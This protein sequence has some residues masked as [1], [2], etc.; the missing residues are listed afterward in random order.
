MQKRRRKRRSRWLFF[1]LLFLILVL[2]I[3]LL[4]RAGVILC[5]AQSDRCTLP[6]PQPTE[7]QV[8][9]PSPAPTFVPPSPSLPPSPSPSPSPTP[10]PPR[11]V[12]FAVEAIPDAFYQEAEERGF[13]QEVSLEVHNIDA[14]EEIFNRDMEIYCPPG[15]SEAEK[16]DVLILIHGG[17]GSYHAFTLEKHEANT[18]VWFAFRDLYDNMIREDLCK[19]LIVVSIGSTSY[20]PSL[21]GTW[22]VSFDQFADDLRTAVLP[23]LAEHFATFAAS[24]EETDLQN[25]REH[26][27]IG[28]ISNGS[29]FAIN[30]GMT[31]CFDLF[32]NYIALSGN[33][34]PGE[35]A[36][37]INSDAWK[38]LPITC[39]YAGSGW[40]DNQQFNS[41]NGYQEIRNS[42]SRLQEGKNCFY[43]DVDGKHNYAAWVIHIYNALQVAFRR[44]LF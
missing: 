27:G 35:A 38:D 33:S 22:D 42:T 19:P 3:L 28:G 12:D 6:L 44:Q 10:A 43:L 26:F 37:A 9:L 41:L 30:S 8:P 29:L 4:L 31:R 21:G 25:A 23:Y 13:I 40:E 34:H 1:V 32:G 17:A 2:G 20:Y 36:Q 5:G 24:G 39:F 14:P 7:A 18:G 15:Y 16:Y 11:E